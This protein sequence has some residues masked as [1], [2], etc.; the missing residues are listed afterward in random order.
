MDASEDTTASWIWWSFMVAA[1]AYHSGWYALEVGK[2]F[3][4]PAQAAASPAKEAPRGRKRTMLIL[5]FP[6]LF[7]IAW[8]SVFPAEYAGNTTF[9][10]S[11][12]NSVMM[13]RLMAAV[14]E[15]CFAAQLAAAICWVTR[16]LEHLGER[17]QTLKNPA[18]TAWTLRI[19]RRFAKFLVVMVVVAQCCATTATAT[20]NL[21]WFVAEGAIWSAFFC[22][23]AFCGWVLGSECS[24]R[25]TESTDAFFTRILFL[26][27]IPSAAY[28]FLDYCPRVYSDWMRDGQQHV[29]F[30]QGFTE[31]LY[32]RVPSRSWSLWRNECVWISLYFV[33][34]GNAAVRCVSSPP[35]LRV[36]DR[37]D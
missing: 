18:R 9:F 33:F 36:K 20:K 35:G 22:I 31:A 34:G 29:H 2:Y 3:Y 24:I 32:H 21:F 5:A 27:S 25:A 7:Q 17:V 28:M 11:G 1:S 16:D 8:R 4:P 6:Y 14:G 23:T 30:A 19:V 15:T 12:A 13:E 10:D 37:R 26:A